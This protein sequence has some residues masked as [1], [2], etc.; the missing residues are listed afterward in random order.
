M[1]FLSIIDCKKNL[2]SLHSS[3]ESILI[4]HIISYLI[5]YFLF[6]S[7]LQIEFKCERD[8][9]KSFRAQ[10]ERRS[11][12]VYIASYYN[13]YFVSFMLY[14]F[15]LTYFILL[16]LCIVLYWSLLVFNCVS[17]SSYEMFYLFIR[18]C[19]WFHKYIRLFFQYSYVHEFYL[20]FYILYYML[21]YDGRIKWFHFSMGP[22]Y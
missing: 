21:Y 8:E 11:D 22:P 19:F 10:F 5:L 20:I 17:C 15:I 6:L 3:I 4:S 14:C 13:V 18:V 12:Q 9:K 1:V 2:L 7:G 16:F